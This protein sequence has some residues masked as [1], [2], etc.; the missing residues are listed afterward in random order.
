[1]V[2]DMMYS[3]IISYDFELGELIINERTKYDVF[4]IV[5]V[6]LG[7]ETRFKVI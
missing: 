5:N 3:V 6:G 1:M 4:N 2:V 7:T